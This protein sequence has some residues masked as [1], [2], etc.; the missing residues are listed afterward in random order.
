MTCDHVSALAYRYRRTLNGVEERA[1]SVSDRGCGKGRP[2]TFFGG[3]IA[4][5]DL[6]AI[7]ICGPLSLSPFMDLLRA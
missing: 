1:A 2:R 5:A 6:G 3:T 4:T 7:E